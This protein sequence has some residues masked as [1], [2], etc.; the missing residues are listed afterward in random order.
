MKPILF[1]LALLA[2]GSNVSTAGADE[3]FPPITNKTVLQEC[4]DC[5]MAFQP[6]FL[7]KRSWI[8]M[9]AGLSDHFGED[10]SLDAAQAKEIEAYL[11]ANAADVSRFREGRKML[12]RV[13]SKWTPLRISEL[14]RF[15]HEH[16]DRDVKRMLDRLKVKTMAACQA[17]HRG[18]TQGYF[19][20]D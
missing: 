19:D 12:R 5:H 6:Q 10:A 13:D 2:A 4:G 14:P 7:P 15:R 9:M 16:D 3:R 1:A 11:T 18:A 17:C 8:K 20:D